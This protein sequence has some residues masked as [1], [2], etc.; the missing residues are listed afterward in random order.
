MKT[1]QQQLKEAEAML[2]SVH[3]QLEAKEDK[4]WPKYD[5]MYWFLY[6][7]G[8]AAMDPWMSSPVDNNRLSVGNVYHT[9][10]EA[11]KE[12]A[13][14]K[15]MKKLKDLAGGFVPN[16]ADHLES[17]YSIYFNRREGV[18][19]VNDHTIYD[20]IGQVYFPTEKAAQHAIDVLG[21]ELDV[22]L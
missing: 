20:Y 17:K 21:D 9:K 2:A 11:E 10:E 8:T 3:K 6:A 13:R 22:L 1:L 15:V 14:R 5:D 7:E 16:W 12:A 4:T 18:F 19:R